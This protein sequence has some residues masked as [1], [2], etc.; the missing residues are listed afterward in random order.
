MRLFRVRIRDT[1][2]ECMVIDKM[3]NIAANSEIQVTVFCITYNQ[4]K[5]IQKTLEGFVSQK[6]AF[7]FEVLVHDDASTDGTAEIIRAYE[8]KYPKIIKPVYQKKNQYSQGVKI[9]SSILMPKAKGKYFAF[10]EGDDYWCDDLKLQKQ[11]DIMEQN[12]NCSICVHKVQCVN[13]DGTQNERVIPEKMYQLQDGLQ[14]KEKIADCI[15]RI[16]GYPFH[17]SSFFLRREVM[18]ERE[19]NK[20]KYADYFNGDQRWIRYALDSGDFWYLDETM[21]CRR[22]WSEGNWSSRYEE[23]SSKKKC[24]HW[25]RS[26]KGNYIYDKEAGGTYHDAVCQCEIFLINRIAWLDASCL[27]EA[28]EAAQ[29]TKKE[30]LSYL[31]LKES[32][33]FRIAQ[34]APQFYK[35]LRKLKSLK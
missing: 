34:R 20:P 23:Q 18:V 31:P 30:W 3:E 21:S 11:F 22:L 1:M 2:S 24:A 10:C 13:E 26:I 6:T 27:D 12:S 8:K 32:M 16:A 29:M 5:Y 19:K 28:L 4:E 7:P 9:I 14:S 15:F 33:K 35:F 17:T 25:I